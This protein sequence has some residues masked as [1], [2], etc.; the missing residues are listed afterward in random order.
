MI[1]DEL[2]KK[3]VWLMISKNETCNYAKSRTEKV[4]S[5]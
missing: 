5:I 3:K 2:K 1:A 4:C